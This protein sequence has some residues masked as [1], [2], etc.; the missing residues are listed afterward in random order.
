MK[1]IVATFAELV[2]ILKLGLSNI[3]ESITS[4]IFL[5][6]YT[7]KQLALTRLVILLD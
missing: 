6:I 5:N 7:P 4:H 3:S 1:I 2:A